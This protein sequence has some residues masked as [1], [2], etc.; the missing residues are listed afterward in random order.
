MF[1]TA[2]AQRH[3]VRRW[4]GVENLK[5]KP[6]DRMDHEGMTKTCVSTAGLISLTP[7]VALP[8]H[9]VSL[10]TLTNTSMW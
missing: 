4:F 3:D 7:T 2:C 6:P 10:P 1:D 5:V 9:Q 8:Q